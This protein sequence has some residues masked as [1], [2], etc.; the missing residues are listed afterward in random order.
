MKNAT[1]ILFYLLPFFVVAQQKN[2]STK[3]AKNTFFVELLGN[4]GI[5][6]IGYDKIILTKPKFKLSG[7]I[8][9]FYLKTNNMIA[10]YYLSIYSE[11]TILFGEKHYLE[12]GPGISYNYG[13]GAC[14]DCGTY[15]Y[16]SYVSSII[17]L[18]MRVLGYRLQKTTGGFYLRAGV[19]FFIRLHQYDEYLKTHPYE[20]GGSPYFPSIGLGIGYTLK[21][22]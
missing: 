7:K 2:D 4:G 22:K 15:K 12:F 14:K 13:A 19:L 1:V 20:A 3:I 16:Y 9:G 5:G 17:Y 11:Q 21:N 10:P 6:S 18:S 8:G